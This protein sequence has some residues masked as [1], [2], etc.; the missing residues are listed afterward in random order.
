[1]LTLD[2]IRAESLR[3]QAPEEYARLRRKRY[4][5]GVDE[6]RPVVI[7][8]NTIFASLAARELLA[9]LHPYRDDDNANYARLTISLTQTR[10]ESAADGLRR[11]PVQPRGAQTCSANSIAAVARNP[12]RRYGNAQSVTVFA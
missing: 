11:A 6:E 9:R 5:K 10:F 2:R 1:V 7:S 3:R 12:S 4:I 8:V